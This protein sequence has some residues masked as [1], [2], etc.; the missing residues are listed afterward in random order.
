MRYTWA[1]AHTH[2]PSHTPSPGLPEG[3]VEPCD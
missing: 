2:T 1:H 3:R